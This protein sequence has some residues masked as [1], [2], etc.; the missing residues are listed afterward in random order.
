MKQ[1]KATKE[2]ELAIELLEI[3]RTQEKVELTKELFSTFESLKPI[4]LLKQTLKEI[5][6]SSEIK[7][8]LS[9]IAIGMITGYIAKKVA[10][11]NTHNPFKQVAGIA[12]EMLV[13]TEATENSGSIKTFVSSLFNKFKTS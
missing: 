1:L 6:S 5:V 9:S 2:L 8:D 10:I 11:G 4:N 7:K 12:L 13:A 3:K